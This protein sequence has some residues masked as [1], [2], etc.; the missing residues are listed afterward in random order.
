MLSPRLLLVLAAM[1]TSGAA[2]AAVLIVGLLAG[3]RLLPTA[4][5]A[6]VAA[7][8]VMPGFL[9]SIGATTRT[10]GRRREPRVG[11]MQLFDHLPLAARVALY[12][13]F[14]AFWLAAMTSFIGIGGN[15]M[16]QDGQYVLTNH[17]TV[18]V[19][20][21]ATYERQLALE[22]RLALGALGGFGVA[23]AALCSAI[24]VRTRRGLPIIETLDEQMPR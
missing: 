15:A 5:A 21:K 13:L 11:L 12:G 4:T 18:T 7:V 16:I 23:A 17:G 19:V 20:D 8:L 22:Q 1:A 14:F 24:A 3:V 10:L 6:T 2:W 9:A